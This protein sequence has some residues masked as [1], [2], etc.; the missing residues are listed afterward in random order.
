MGR[1][2]SSLAVKKRKEKEKRE[3]KKR[4]R[5]NRGK[6]RPEKKET[7]LAVGKD[8]SNDKTLSSGDNQ[9]RAFGIFPEGDPESEQD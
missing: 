5:K 9:R 8:Q 3:K 1:S 2:S 4:N 7:I 6:E